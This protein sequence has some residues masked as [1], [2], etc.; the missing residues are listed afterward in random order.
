MVSNFL[1]PRSTPMPTDAP[2]LPRRSYQ[3][4]AV[5]TRLKV[6]Q[7]LHD[8]E[9]V[10]EHVA[11]WLGPAH[12]ASLADLAV[13]RIKQDASSAGAPAVDTPTRSGNGGSRKHIEARMLLTIHQNSKALDWKA[14]EWADY[15]R[16]SPGT[17]C[18]NNVWRIQ[19]PK[20]RALEKKARAKHPSTKSEVVDN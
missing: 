19:I 7:F 13:K 11:K 8:A 14:R 4:A 20:L 2:I 3:F 12:R 1:R 18:G 6:E 15:L 9:V 17:V 10:S 16:C 5:R